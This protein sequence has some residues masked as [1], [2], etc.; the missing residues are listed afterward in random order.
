MMIGK[1]LFLLSLFLVTTFVTPVFADTKPASS[2]SAWLIDKEK[3]E[4]KV[5]AG[6]CSAAFNI[7]WPYVKDD[8]VEAQQVMLSLMQ[9]APFLNLPGRSGD[10]IT[11]VRDVIILAAYSPNIEKELSD[12]SLSYAENVRGS[13]EFF[14]CRSDPQKK[15]CASSLKQKKII[16]PFESFIKEI[17]SLTNSGFVAT[18]SESTVK[19]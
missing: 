4:G 19:N 16:P 3:L 1:T 14:E 12:L 2:G 7:L 11:R 10:Y 6:E 5:E 13:R 18:C 8:N 9:F 15:N 17:E